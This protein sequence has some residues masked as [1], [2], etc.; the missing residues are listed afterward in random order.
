MADVAQDSS[1][2]GAG[3]EDVA[4]DGGDRGAGDDEADRTVVKDLLVATMWRRT[5]VK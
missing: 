5:V 3:G 1:R 2:P 4:H